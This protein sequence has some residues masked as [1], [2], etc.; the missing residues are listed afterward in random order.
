VSYLLYA[1]FDLSAEGQIRSVDTWSDYELANGIGNVGRIN[2]IVKNAY[3]NLKALIS[4]G[5]WSLSAHFSTV[6]ASPELRSAF[7]ANAEAFLERTGFDGLDLDWE[8]KLP[9]Q[10]TNIW[11][12]P[13]GGGLPCNTM[14][15]NDNA[16]FVALLKALRERLGTKYTITIAASASP[17]RYGNYL[18]EIAGQL[19][20][21]N[22]MTYDFT[23]NW[24]AKTGLN[25]ALYSDSQDPNQQ[26]TVDSA[27]VGFLEAGIP[28]SKLT[29]GLGFY[30]HSWQTLSGTN[31]GLYQT[32]GPQFDLANPRPCPAP[33]GDSFDALWTDPCG[34]TSLSGVWSWMGL[35]TSGVLQSATEAG[36]GW[37]RTWRE[38]GKVP[39]LWNPTTKTFISYDDPSSIAAKVNYAKE[40]GLGGLM[41]WELSQ[42]YHG[43]LMNGLIKAWSQ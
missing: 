24:L 14:S 3:P 10:T 21:I 30:G 1:F 20:F 19:D 34:S 27:I 23:G 28:A 40:T 33:K 17:S 25:S 35:R 6:A 32:C 2:T 13:T 26:L 9:P 36:S 15:A 5:G 41:V 12:D 22:V 43:E 4:V 38:P 18:S 11:P 16:N 7:A 29:L 42:D 37:E 39:T 8:C 31:N